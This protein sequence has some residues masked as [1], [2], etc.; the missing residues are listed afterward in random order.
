MENILLVVHSQT[1]ILMWLL[2]RSY[3]MSESHFKPLFFFQI[4]QSVHSIDTEKSKL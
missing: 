1:S 4:V 2:L 3:A